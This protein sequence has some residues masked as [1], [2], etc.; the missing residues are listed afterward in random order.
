MQGGSEF[1]LGRVP[2]ENSIKMRL[3]EKNIGKLFK[4]KRI[5]KL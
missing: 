3:Y 4:K 2:K 1:F 5:C